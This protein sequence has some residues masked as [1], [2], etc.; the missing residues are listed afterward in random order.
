MTW[1]F[2]GQNKKYILYSVHYV[3]KDGKIGEIKINF[4]LQFSKLHKV[5][6][7]IESTIISCSND[8]F[9]KFNQFF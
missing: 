5:N 1:T 6:Q 7:Q 8:L 3:Y 9:N 4:W 2:L